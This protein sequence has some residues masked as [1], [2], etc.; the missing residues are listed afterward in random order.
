M[1]FYKVGFGKSMSLIIHTPNDRYFVTSYLQGGSICSAAW[2][3]IIVLNNL[4]F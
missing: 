1:G 2:R 4:C 3:L